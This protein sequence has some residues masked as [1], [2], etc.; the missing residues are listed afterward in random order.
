MSLSELKAQLLAGRNP[1]GGWPYYAGKSSRLEPTAWALLAL[2]AAGE[3][4]TADALTGWPRRDGWFVDRSS[5][6]VNVAF[7]ALAAIALRAIDPQ[8]VLS[9]ACGKVLVSAHGERIAPSSIN[10]Q[11]NSLQGWSWTKG[12][13]SWIEPTAWALIALKRLDGRDTTTQSRIAEGERVLFDR[14]CRDGGWNHGN[15]NM[16]GA[17]LDPYVPTSAIGLIA[18]A[19]RRSHPAVVQTHHYLRSARRRE[20]ATMALSLTSVALALYGDPV[21]DVLA[22]VDAAV[23]RTDALN[24]LHS[25]ALA[26]Y[27]RAGA[28]RKYEALRV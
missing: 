9:A 10:R 7:N 23:E 19:D 8:G 15:S 20:A 2:Q 26:L 14:V 16:L 13:F 6:E 22:E 5:D 11:D 18:L 17:D 1:D 24:N 4:V 28:S 25:V 12:T 21:V 3:P 27:A